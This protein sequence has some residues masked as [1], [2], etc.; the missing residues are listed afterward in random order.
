MF[1]LEEILFLA[2]FLTQKVPLGPCSSHETVILL[3]N[4]LCR[5]QPW[6]RGGFWAMEETYSAPF[7]SLLL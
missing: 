1:W 6:S 5:G 7:W 4:Q 3:S 2:A